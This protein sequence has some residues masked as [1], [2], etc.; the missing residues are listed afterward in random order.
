[1]RNTRISQKALHLENTRMY[2]KR[3]PNQMFFD[4]HLPFGGKLRA[5]NRWVI[6]S[7]QIPWDQIE[8]DYA[9]FFEG[10]NVGC[11]AKTSRV[12]LGALIVKERL[13]L[14][15]RETV[16][17][18]QENPYLQFFLGFPGYTDKE[19][20]HHTSMVHFRKRFD[21]ETLAQINDLIVQ[22]A[23]KN[24]QEQTDETQDDTPKDN[25]PPSN[26]G[27]LLVDAT[28]T[29]A[30]ITF[31]TDVKLL[32]EAREKT[33]EII[34]CMHST[35]IGKRPKPR[36]YRK[37]A[38]KDYLALIKQKSPGRK[39]IRKA[40]RK[41]LG[42]VGRNLK[43]IEGMASEGLLHYLGKRLYRLLLVSQ[44]LYRQQ[45]WMYQNRCHRI[46]DRI[47]SLYQP[48]VRPIVRG[49][50]HAPVEFGAKV[51]I[52]LVDG[53]S[54]VDVLSWDAYNESGD[55]E[56][57][58]ESYRVRYGFY[59]ESVH[60]DKIYRTR[61]NRR[62][63]KK[64]GIRLSGPPLGRPKQVTE[65]NKEELQAI[66]CQQRQDE[67]DR[68][69][70]EGKF[71]QGKRRFTLNRIMAKLAETSEAVIMVSFIV[72]NLEKILSSILLCFLGAWH[73]ARDLLGAGIYGEYERVRRCHGV[74]LFGRRC[75]KHCLE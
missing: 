43:T 32:N 15:D 65:S 37:K 59:P 19:P 52:S 47:V 53:F 68:I 10:S 51:S 6:L 73:E 22:K 54:F 75:G 14:T 69:A 1:M 39:K 29:P 67:I 70:V 35:L 3:N 25:T 57:Q 62:Y 71:G 72:M 16:L 5:D 42:Y 13:K 2:K 28:C 56:G 64:Y 49:K 18:I 61:D 17:Q 26:Q 4:F 33:E 46:G 38:R 44:E 55:L 7:E 27:K 31:P 60:A 74:V 30:D 21:Q 48:H 66:K 50:A 20:F 12:A 24:Q 58:I 63:C 45:L 34:D 9:G 23:L 41:Q 11:S 40:I 36:T 8:T